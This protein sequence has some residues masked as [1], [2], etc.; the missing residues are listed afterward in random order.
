[1]VTFLLATE[2]ALAINDYE[3]IYW[4]PRLP[5]EPERCWACGLACERPPGLL[6]GRWLGDALALLLGR[7]AGFALAFPA[8]FRPA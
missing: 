5:R 3:V 4:P 8:G 6:V 2:F 1:M 7:R